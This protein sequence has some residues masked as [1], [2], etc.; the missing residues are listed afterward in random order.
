MLRVFSVGFVETSRNSCPS[1]HTTASD[2]VTGEQMRSYKASLRE[3][4][5]GRLTNISSE[6]NAQRHVN[7]LI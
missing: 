2:K 1:I 7:T 5:E 6:N 4:P 3:A